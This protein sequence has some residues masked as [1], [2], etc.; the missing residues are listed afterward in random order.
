M[1]MTIR[2]QL[3]LAHHVTLSDEVYQRALL[4]A[5]EG[6]LDLVEYLIEE[7]L[8]SKEVGCRLWSDRI[9]SAY[10]DPLST[11]IS[12][13]AIC[14]IPIEIA[15][16][17]NIM[18]LYEIE[19]ALTVAM[20]DPYNQ[21]LI[22]RLAAI[23]GKDISPVFCLTSEVHDAIELHYSTDKSVEELIDQLE[24]SQGAILAKLRPD[25]LEG[26]S[27]SKSIVGLCD[28][29]L[30]LAIKE[31]ASD[32]HM[33]PR[34]DSTNIRFRIDGR[35]QHVFTIAAA[36]HA[37][38]KS[39]IK[40]LSNLN[41]AESRFP[42][43]GRFSVPL[44]AE[45]VNFRV[46]VIPTIYGEKLVLRILALTGKK[47][48]R[49]LDQML[50]SQSILEPFKQVIRNPN[51]MIFV[52]GPTGSGK[53]TTLYAALHEIN[54]P[55]VNICTIEDPVETQMTGIIQ[56]QVN[57]SIELNFSSLL[58]SLLRQDPDVILVGEIRDLETAKIA[59]EAAL[60]GHLVFSTL[61]T[62]NAIQAVVRLIELGIEP[63]MVAPSL[64]A[65]LAQRLAARICEHCK[66]SYTPDE[67]VLRKFFYDYKEVEAP[68]FYEG[69]GCPHC[70]KTG[71]RGRIAF[72]EMALVTDE[73]R[74]LISSG[75][76]DAELAA[77]AKK[78]G[79]RPLRYDGLKKVL[80]GF[81]TVE[82]LEAHAS[83]DWVG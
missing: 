13:E 71:Y 74:A 73:M 31:R 60:T 50:I 62:N 59:T 48:F 9:E 10:V 63:Y 29:L 15:R 6:T 66:R 2:E 47:D 7:G 82:E 53:S 30:Y 75:G 70:R 51:G 54:S 18:P 80:L 17:G 34:E 14:S 4:S 78:V 56:S 28:A 11:I 20:P 67:D 40:I 58:R 42:Q 1:S 57:A 36:L 38:L 27:E 46:S 3:Q 26:M 39:R 81:T 41:I 8:I 37:P 65:V 69:Q 25:E 45:Q 61:H 49:T 16:K 72:H 79:Y 68:V 76:S 43:D 22:D 64:L 12:E 83:F 33:E 21:P 55:E 19:S 35:L 24:K 5:E 23:T 52:T 44:G 77:A 32:I